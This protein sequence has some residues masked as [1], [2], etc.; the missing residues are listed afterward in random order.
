MSAFSVLK[1]LGS[2][3]ILLACM[4]DQTVLAIDPPASSVN[5]NVPATPIS[6]A[7]KTI[8]CPVLEC[9]DGKMDNNACF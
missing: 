6:L 2:A 9:E 3:A 4:K 5:A 8:K 7:P 1:K